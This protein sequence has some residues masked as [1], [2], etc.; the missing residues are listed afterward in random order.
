MKNKTVVTCCLFAFLGG[1]LFL[2]HGY[3]TPLK[4]F[5]GCYVQNTVKPIDK[6]CVYQNGKYEQFAFDDKHKT[7]VSYNIGLWRSYLTKEGNHEDVGVVL[8][9][10]LDNAGVIIELDIFPYKNLFGKEI[11]VVHG[12]EFSESKFYIKENN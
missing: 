11:F 6:I 8:N 9:K 7:L 3:S 10:Y 4:D 1:C 5:K 2:F 12:D